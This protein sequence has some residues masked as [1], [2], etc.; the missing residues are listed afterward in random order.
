[1][2]ERENQ[3]MDMLRRMCEATRCEDC[4]LSFNGGILESI[5]KGGICELAAIMAKGQVANGCDR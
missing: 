4:P 5:T 2:T 3:L 1:M